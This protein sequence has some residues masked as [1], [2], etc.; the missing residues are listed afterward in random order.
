MIISHNYIGLGNVIEKA[1]KVISGTTSS[2]IM[3]WHAS[4]TT[5]ASFSF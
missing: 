5:N 1:P 2:R 3:W 4:K